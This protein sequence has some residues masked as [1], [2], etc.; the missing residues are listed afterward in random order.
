MSAPRPPTPPASA[1]G[2]V[3]APIDW[4]AAAWAGVIAGLV[5][6]ITEMLLVWLVM[7][8]SPW[9][10]P[11]MMAAIVLGPGVLPPPADFAWAP[12]LTALVVHLPLSALYGLCIGGLVQR[13]DTARAALIG[14]AF[15]LAVYGV[16]FH[17]IAPLA[18]PWFME[19]RHAVSVLGHA[20]F[21]GVAAAV[22]VLM[23]QPQAAG[24]GGP[25]SETTA[26]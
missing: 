14:V 3:H 15:G 8:Q 17:L 4:F 1:P 16:N 20:L 9:G 13:R 23:R 25:P 12:V 10:P 19:A 11:R 6:L 24:S 5:F 26:P 18:F 21:G 22:Y 2:Q 7:G